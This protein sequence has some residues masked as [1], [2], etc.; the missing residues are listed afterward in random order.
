MQPIR[1]IAVIGAGN[2]G[3]AADAQLSHRG[4]SVRL[5]GRS[6]NTTDPLTAIGGIEYEGALGEGFAPLALITNDAGAAV[7]GADLVLIMA[8]THAHAAIARMLA[9][10]VAP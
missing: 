8:P 7:A 2:G 9:P 10:H 4:F 5:Y 6:P 1:S 3:C